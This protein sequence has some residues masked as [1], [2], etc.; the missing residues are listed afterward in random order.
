MSSNAYRRNHGTTT[1]LLE[2]ADAIF[3][4]MDM[5]KMATVMTVDKS[6]AF[7]CMEHNMML[8]KIKVYNFG[9]QEVEWFKDY[10]SFRS[11]YMTIKGKYSR[12]KTVTTGVPQGL[13]LR[14]V[15]FMIYV[16]ELPEAL[17]EQNTCEEDTHEEHDTLF[18]N[19]CTTCGV[20]RDRRTKWD[21][22]ENL[23]KV[24]TFLNMNGLMMNALKT[25]VV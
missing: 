12:M 5:N 16:N 19:N 17:M 2:I 10:L 15:R 7:D 8:E 25:T 24:H 14:P 20:T 9:E 3:T 11:Q 1:T 23:A 18:R 6:S 13:V 4:A 22:R 21:W